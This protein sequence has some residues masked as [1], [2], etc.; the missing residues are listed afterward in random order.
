MIKQT[1]IIETD[2]IHALRILEE[3][4]ALKLIRIRKNSV[5]KKDVK[6]PL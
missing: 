6:K 2:N 1:L 4:V 3:L 5:E